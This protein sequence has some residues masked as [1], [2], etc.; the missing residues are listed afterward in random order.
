[1]SI[2]IPSSVTSLGEACFYKC[3][4]LKTVIC[5]IST[6]IS[7]YSIFEGTPIN[8]ATLYV[9]EASLASY[10]TTRPWSYFGTILPIESSGIESN[11][12]GT[13][14]DVEAVYGLD[15]KRCDSMKSGMNIIRMSDGTTKKIVK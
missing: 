4:S 1:M 2:T 15:G 11:T 10:K 7:G 5:E 3:Y 8:E 14:A 12:I 6:P 9:P 13:V